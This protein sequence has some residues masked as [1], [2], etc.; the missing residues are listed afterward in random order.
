MLRSITLEQFGSFLLPVTIICY[1]ALLLK[2]YKHD[3]VAFF[4]GDN[5]RPEGYPSEAE[6]AVPPIGTGAR[7]RR[8]GRKRFEGQALTPPDLEGMPIVVEI[9]T[10]LKNRIV[11]A[12]GCGI[13]GD[14]LEIRVREV[15]DKYPHVRDTP[16]QEVVN[17][18]VQRS[19]LISTPR[20]PSQSYT[21]SPHP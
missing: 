18:F 11:Q 17:S 5:G 7:D 15:L 2:Y 19:L 1:V 9:T 13:H 12:Q 4:S 6:G 3:L 8:T 16:Y 14:E 10:E 20:S 21:T